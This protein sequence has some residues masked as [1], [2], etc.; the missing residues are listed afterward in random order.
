MITRSS[1]VA[2]V[3]LVIIFP[4]AIQ[5]QS[6]TSQQEAIKL[7]S[8]LDSLNQ[9]T[10]YHERQASS[11]RLKADS[12]ARRLEI[13]NLYLMQTQGDKYYNFHDIIL[14]D[15]PTVSG[16]SI[17]VIP[18][19]TE[20]T[21]YDEQGIYLKVQAG[22]LIGWVSKRWL[23]KKEP[24]KQSSSLNLLDR[25]SSSTNQPVPAISRS[26]RNCCKVCSKGKACGNS[27]ISR[28]Y[29][30]HKPPGCACNR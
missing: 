22:H 27:C 29:T 21:A 24:S 12:I 11:I 30:C 19:G 8:S 9:L 6:V 25:N 20:L 16:T 5:A 13:T 15:K 3:F 23:S 10:I 7:Q 26:S 18:E 1:F 17:A 14:R 4:L 28:S 2:C